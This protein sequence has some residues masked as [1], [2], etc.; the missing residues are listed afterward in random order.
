MSFNTPLSRVRGLGSAK[1]GT[2]HW[3]A[4]RMTAI[5]LVPLTIIMI[6]IIVSTTLSDYETARATVGHPLGAVLAIVLA[7]VIF[8]HGQ[9]GMQ[10]VIEDYVHIEWVKLTALITV[11]FASIVLALLAIVSVLRIAIGS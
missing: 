4:Q 8:Y 10:V 11:K 7:A 9:L 1:D 5:A 2:H 3:W 6:V